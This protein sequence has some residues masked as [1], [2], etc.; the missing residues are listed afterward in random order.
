MPGRLRTAFGTSST[1]ENEIAK[2]NAR[3][4]KPKLPE[5]DKWAAARGPSYGSFRIPPPSYL[6]PGASLLVLH[7]KETRQ[8]S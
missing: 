6:R 2:R 5:L 3:A 8:R 1:R 7:K 4:L